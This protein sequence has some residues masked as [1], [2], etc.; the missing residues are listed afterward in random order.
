MP[1]ALC[2]LAKQIP[3]NNFSRLFTMGNTHNV[4]PIVNIDCLR[5]QILFLSRLKESYAWGVHNV[6]QL[7]CDTSFLFGFLASQ[8]L[9]AFSVGVPVTSSL[10]D[11][12]I[13]RLFKRYVLNFSSLSLIKTLSQLLTYVF[14]RYLL[15]HTDHNEVLCKLGHKPVCQD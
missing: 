12:D 10:V 5:Q 11:D 13:S 2:L 1:N 14:I 6:P 8:N 7:L 4:N 9:L 15:L 3:H